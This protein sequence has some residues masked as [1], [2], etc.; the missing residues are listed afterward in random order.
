MRVR[1]LKA[2]GGLVPGTDVKMQNDGMLEVKCDGETLM[3]ISYTDH[4][5]SGPDLEIKVLFESVTMP[6]KRVRL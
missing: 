6:V 2:D 1:L 4:P 5:I 3:Q